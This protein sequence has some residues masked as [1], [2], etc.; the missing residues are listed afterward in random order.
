MAT[1]YGVKIQGATAIAL[2]KLDVLSYMEKIPVCTAYEIDGERT[3][4]FPFPVL[5]DRAN[6]VVEY[7]DGWHC[8]ISGARIWADL[9]EAARNYVE[10]IERAVGC[11]IRYVSVGPERDAIIRR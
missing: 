1:R 4:E 10:R 2:T 11:P 9:P 7:V 8:D 5:L 3:E 6:P